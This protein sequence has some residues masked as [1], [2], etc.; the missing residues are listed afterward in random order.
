MDELLVF[1]IKLI[2]RAVNSASESNSA[3]KA[4]ARVPAAPAPIVA[5]TPVATRGRQAAVAA[6]GK[7]LPRS[8]PAPQ[9][10]TSTKRAATAEPAAAAPA[11]SPATQ[12]AE[13]LRSRKNIATA[14]MMTELVLPPVALRRG[15]SN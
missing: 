10:V 12:I 5:A 8:A 2:I 7:R 6:R 1:I 9:A 14:L 11:T 13:A 15:A 3:R 4:A